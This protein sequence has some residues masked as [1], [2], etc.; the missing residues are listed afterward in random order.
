MYKLLQTVL[1][2]TI[3]KG[4]SYV[5]IGSFAANVFNYFFHLITGRMLGPEQYSVVAALLSLSYVFGFPSLIISTVTTRKTAELAALKDFRAINGVLRFVFRGLTVFAVVMTILFMAFQETIAEFLKIEDSHLVVVL[6]A[7]LIISYFSTV[8]LA[9]LQGMLRF[10]S[11]AIVNAVSGLFKDLFALIAV[12]AGYGAGGVVWSLLVTSVATTIVTA[13]PLLDVVKTKPKNHLI[14]GTSIASTLWVS[15]AF[16]G[17]GLMIN[18]DVLIVKH[19]FL[20]LEAGLYAGL[21]TMG[22]IVL[23]LSTPIATVLLPVSTQKHARG[24]STVKE[25]SLAM[26]A[27][28]LLSLFIITAFIV[29]PE[30]SIFLMYGKDYYAISPYLWAMGAYFLFYNICF[31]FIHYF[32]SI[33]RYRILTAPLIIAVLQ[34]G[35]LVIYHETFTQIIT[36]LVVTAF[37]L[38]FIF[39]YQYLSHET[40]KK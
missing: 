24:H 32:I 8:G 33:K 9:A 34:V 22:K 25:L 12:V 3:I 17:M 28:I 11:Y 6:G 13:V 30:F 5:F 4:A 38:S 31:T 2:N 35:L 14:K 40:R 21:A 15:S 1:A 20:P 39:G 26:G 16:I 27:V 19:Y 10:V 18:M 7:S 23:F 29:L 36:T 37:L